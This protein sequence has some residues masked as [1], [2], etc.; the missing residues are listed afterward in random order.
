MKNVKLISEK[1]ETDV[2]TSKNT[3]KDILPAA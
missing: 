3:D 2:T 1:A